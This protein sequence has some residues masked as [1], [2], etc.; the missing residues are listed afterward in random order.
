VTRKTE[1]FLRTAAVL[2]P[3]L[4]CACVM[5][6]AMTI[7]SLFNDIDEAAGWFANRLIGWAHAR[8]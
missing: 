4:A 2:A 1:M 8:D 7:A 6:L 5:L 3:V